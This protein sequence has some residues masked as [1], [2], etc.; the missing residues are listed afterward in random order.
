MDLIRPASTGEAA[1]APLLPIRRREPP[2][3]AANDG[4]AGDPKERNNRLAAIIGDTIR[5]LTDEA[6]A[7]VEALAESREE[8]LRLH[9]E[10]ERL[11]DESDHAAGEARRREEALRA[12]LDE[13]EAERD[14]A[15]RD[16]ANYKA[17]ASTWQKRADQARELLTPTS[18]IRT[19]GDQ[20]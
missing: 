7:N 19:T 20:Q 6:N 11:R 2:A 9:G 13:A 1:G 10:L 3:G 4:A 14:A 15:R 16:A 5:K 8:A 17:I 18:A 12:R